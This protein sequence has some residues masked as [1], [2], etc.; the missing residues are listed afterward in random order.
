MAATSE[1]EA[2]PG[3]RCSDCGSG[4]ARDL[5]GRGFRRHLERRP[6]RR[7]DGTTIYDDEGNPLMCGGTENS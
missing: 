5:V 1:V 7:P 6:K 3:E 2:Q 4:F